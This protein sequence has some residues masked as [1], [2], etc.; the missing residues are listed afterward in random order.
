MRT[1]MPPVVEGFQAAPATGPLADF[2]LGLLAADRI[3]VL[4]VL[5]RVGVDPL[6]DFN[7]T[8]A[9]V[10]LVGHV[11]GLLRDVADLA[12]KGDLR[13]LN[14]VEGEVGVRMGLGCGEDL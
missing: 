8:G 1:N 11:R 3:A 6:L 14:I 7:A 2:Q 10:K 9:I 5:G 4:V 13:D 12:H